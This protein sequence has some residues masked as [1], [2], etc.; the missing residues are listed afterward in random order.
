MLRAG[1]PYLDERQDDD[2]SDTDSI[3]T[4]YTAPEGEDLE[5]PTNLDHREVVKELA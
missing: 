4:V 3:S 1:P 2:S 5:I